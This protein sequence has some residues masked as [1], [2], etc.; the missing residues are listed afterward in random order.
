MPD[1]DRAPLKAGIVPVMIQLSNA[2]NIQVQVG[3]AI[4]VMAEADF[5][6][7]WSDLIDV[8]ESREKSLTA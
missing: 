4:A 6:Y 5:P 2:P 1:A 3:E 8:S 7:D